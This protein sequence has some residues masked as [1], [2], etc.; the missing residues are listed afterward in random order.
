MPAGTCL[1]A[2]HL[3]HG[4]QL[5]PAPLQVLAQQPA[6]FK[7]RTG[8]TSLGMPEATQCLQQVLAFTAGAGT[9]RAV[10]TL[11]EDGICCDVL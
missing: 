2:H 7:M 8:C 10:L 11:L 4:L 3:A 1:L 6:C 5:P 9:Q